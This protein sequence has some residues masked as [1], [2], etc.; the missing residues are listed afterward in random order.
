MGKR[1]V[2]SDS[3]DKILQAG[4]QRYAGFNYCADINIITVS[5]QCPWKTV[6]VLSAFREVWIRIQSTS[7]F[8][9]A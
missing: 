1:S 4:F 3:R 5:I 8:K 2:T 7:V 6:L 9:F